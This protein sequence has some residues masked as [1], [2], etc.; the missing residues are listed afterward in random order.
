M[1]LKYFVT[2]GRGG[3]EQNSRKNTGFFFYKKVTEW[4]KRSLQYSILWQNKRNS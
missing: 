2:K 3:T 4:N 1:C